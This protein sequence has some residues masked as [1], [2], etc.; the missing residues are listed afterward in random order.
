MLGFISRL[1]GV[2]REQGLPVKVATKLADYVRRLVAVGVFE[3][4]LDDCLA[5]RK[6]FKPPEGVEPK[7]LGSLPLEAQTY[8]VSFVLQGCLEG[9]IEDDGEVLAVA[10]YA[11]REG[12]FCTEAQAQVLTVLGLRLRA[13]FN[14]KPED[15][16]EVDQGLLDYQV[17]LG[18]AIADA[19]AFFADP[20]AAETR[21]S[22]AELETFLT[23][24]VTTTDTVEP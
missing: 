11:L 15:Y 5:D 16:D 8:V 19:K 14:K 20:D 9:G 10:D 23:R 18:A 2:A 6:A 7:G 21:P 3:P 12:G 13:V 4:Y 17:I 22:P 24:Y 1:F